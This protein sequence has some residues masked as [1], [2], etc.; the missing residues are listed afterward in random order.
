MKTSNHIQKLID[1][2][3][4][5][6]DWMSARA[7]DRQMKKIMIFLTMLDEWLNTHKSLD[8][9]SEPHAQLDALLEELK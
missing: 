4:I 9:N 6:G 5:K 7:A 8:S 2:N 1:D 3:W